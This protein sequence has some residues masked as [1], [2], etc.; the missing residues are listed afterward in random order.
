M[1]LFEQIY[2]LYLKPPETAYLIRLS[3]N[4][5]NSEVV[6]TINISVCADKCINNSICIQNIINLSTFKLISL[7]LKWYKALHTWA[8]LQML[9]MTFQLK[10]KKNSTG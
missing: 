7:N 1:L 4:K 8:L 6:I 5:K 3:R 2:V 10:L 9:T